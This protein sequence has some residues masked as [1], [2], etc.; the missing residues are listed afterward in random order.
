MAAGGPPLPAHGVKEP[1]LLSE[2]M[3]PDGAIGDEG[4]ERVCGAVA[5]AVQ[6]AERQAIDMLYVVVTSAIRDA[7][8]VT[9]CWARSSAKRGAGS[10]TCPANEEADSPNLRCRRAE[11]AHAVSCN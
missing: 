5:R 3:Q 2:E 4:I 11:T 9:G 6:T 10:S 1:T 8:T 7:A